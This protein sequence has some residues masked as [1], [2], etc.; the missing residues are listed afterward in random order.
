[1]KSQYILTYCDDL[2]LRQRIQKQLN[3]VELSNKFSDAVFWDR[4]K[5]FQVGTKDE[6][7]KYNLCKT[8]I[9]NA[10]IY[11]NY[12]FLSDRLLSTGNQQDREDMIDSIKKG[13]VLAW[14][15][16]NFTGEYDFQFNIPKLKKLKFERMLRQ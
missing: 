7:E 1:M 3:R 15:H 4:G 5:R 14:K 10:I 11:W 8:I 2:E 13:S 6:Q 9:Q 12:L 16:I